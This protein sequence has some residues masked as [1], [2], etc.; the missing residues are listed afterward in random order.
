[1][2]SNLKVVFFGTPSF[3]VPFV[4]AVKDSFNLIAIVT[5]EDKPSG[6]NKK[7]KYSP[8][9]EFA[10]KNDIKLLQPSK[11]KLIKEDLK[12]LDADLFVVVAYGKLIPDEI[13]NLPNYKSINVHPSDLPCFRGPAPM[14]YALLNGN[15]E[16]AISV[17]L[18]DRKMDHGPIL[19]KEIIKI[20]INDNYFD[21]EKNVLIIGPNLLTKTISKYIS[22]EI[23]PTKQTGVVSYCPL[24]K[25]EDA[26]I[27]WDESPLEIHNKIRAYV[28]WPKAYSI[29]NNQ[30]II[31]LKSRLI[32]NRIKLDL[33]QL[34]G[35]KPT[36]WKNFTNGY[37][38]QLPFKLT[39]KLV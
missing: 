25:K 31:F 22:G 6:R 16:T 39:S 33:V 2:I 5:E 27:T 24:I 32:K 7:I 28:M 21:L 8:I 23:K 14:Q 20:D 12:G 29:I 17:M 26:L 35:K 37:K 9:K 38:N 34:E 13:I 10:L 11:L 4:K 30:R 18:I 19:A 3:S 15:K 1:M 36:D